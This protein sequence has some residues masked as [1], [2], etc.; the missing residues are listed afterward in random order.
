MEDVMK[1]M[2]ATLIALATLSSSV[3]AASS[4][5]ASAS[6]SNYFVILFL[7]F[8]ALIVVFQLV[9]AVMMLIGMV[10]GL[11]SEKQAQVNH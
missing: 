4:A 2:L 10:K 6:D 8:F 9:P 11:S 1:K 3:F 5:S 7:G